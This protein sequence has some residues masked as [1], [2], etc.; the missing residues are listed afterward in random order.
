MWHGK[1]WRTGNRYTCTFFCLSTGPALE[2]QIAVQSIEINPRARRHFADTVGHVAH[3]LNEELDIRPR[4][5]RRRYRERILVKREIAVTNTSISVRKGQ[6][7][8]R[9]AKITIASPEAISFCP[10]NTLDLP[11]DGGDI[12]TL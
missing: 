10:L 5:W 6:P 1:Y 12:L 9:M 7:T 2:G 11:V 3:F 8:C 4:G